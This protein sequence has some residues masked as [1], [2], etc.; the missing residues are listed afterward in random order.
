MT[1]EQILDEIMLLPAPE[2]QRVVVSVRKL[3]TGEIPE[4][5]LE[6]LDDFE[7]ERFV[8][9]ETALNEAPPKQ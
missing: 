8:S 3:E 6:A 1:A 7:K 4:D 5:F 9:M 2:R